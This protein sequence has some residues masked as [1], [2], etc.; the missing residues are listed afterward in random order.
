M[1]RGEE[2]KFYEKCLLKKIE[3]EQDDILQRKIINKLSYILI[4]LIIILAIFAIIHH[5]TLFIILFTITVI[6][7]AV[8]TLFEKSNSNLIKELHVANEILNE[9]EKGAANIQ[10][11][12]K[13]EQ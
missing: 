12:H 1:L 11:I 3:L 5:V 13:S 8:R 4:L 10:V 9:I 6:T 2:K 7:L